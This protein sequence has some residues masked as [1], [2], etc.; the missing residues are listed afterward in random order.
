MEESDYITPGMTVDEEEKASLMALTLGSIAPTRFNIS[1]VNY[2]P[3][4]ALK[5]RRK[6]P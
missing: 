3:Q 1:K 5:I 6:L 2:T 4:M